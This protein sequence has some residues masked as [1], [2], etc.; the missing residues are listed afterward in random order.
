MGRRKVDTTYDPDS[1]SHD[2]PL[3]SILD[4]LPTAVFVLDRDGKPFYANEAATDLLGKGVDPAKGSANLAD[5]Y[6]AFIAHSDERYPIRRMPVVRAL[7]GETSTVDDM[8]IRRP[9][10]DVEI[11]VWGAPILDDNGFVRYAVASFKDISQRRKLQRQIR[12]DPL[13][14]LGNRPALR[15]DLDRAIPRLRR[16]DKFL[17]VLFVDLNGFKEINDRFGHL[18]GDRILV[19]VGER[20]RKVS[21]KSE[22]PYRVG[23]DEFV[24]VCDDI[25][26]KEDAEKVAGR[27]H[28]E[29]ERPLEIQD[30]SIQ[31]SAS[32]GFAVTR[33]ADV[34][35]ERLIMLADSD[36]YERKP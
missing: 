33:E 1:H 10:G 6:G 22:R 25:S 34:S 2:D 18:E 12:L 8:V 29:I 3:H 27:L 4:Q 15:S 24:L 7:R 23:G 31:L 16:N 14:G 17:A 20:I 30:Q 11:E 26:K 28:H 19:E 13:T 35:P 32:I 5:T 36:M 21:R 9:G